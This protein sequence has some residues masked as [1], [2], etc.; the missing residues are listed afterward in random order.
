MFRRPKHQAPSSGKVNNL[1]ASYRAIQ[2][3]NECLIGGR[4][5]IVGGQAGRVDGMACNKRQ[6]IEVKVTKSMWLH[7]VSQ[8]NFRLKIRFGSSKTRGSRILGSVTAEILLY[9]MPVKSLL[10]QIC[11]T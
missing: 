11:W 1:E 2:W 5:K 3:H 9:L 10:L 6:D 4:L 8:L 7:S